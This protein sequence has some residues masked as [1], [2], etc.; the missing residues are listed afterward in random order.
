MPTAHALA[1]T[2]AGPSRALANCATGTRIAR[3]DRAPSPHAPAPSSTRSAR[4]RGLRCRRALRSDVV[5][6]HALGGAGDALVFELSLFGFRNPLEDA[7]RD[8][9]GNLPPWFPVVSFV[10]YVWIAGEVRKVRQEQ[11]R[12]AMEK[13]SK[14]AS[15]AAQRKLEGVTPEAWA[16]LLPGA[17]ELADVA[18]APLEAF[19]LAQLFRSSAISGLGF[20]EEALPFTDVLPTA[21]LAWIL[22]EFFADSVVGK[23]VGLRQPE[24]EPHEGGKKD[25]KG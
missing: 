15:A 25:G 23:A 9:D 4:S 20:V 7:A 5:A 6:A 19:L 24:P 12:K 3:L 10:A 2:A 16:K 1:T 21:T 18:Y 13:A 8:A 14:A 17:G 11:E 22:E